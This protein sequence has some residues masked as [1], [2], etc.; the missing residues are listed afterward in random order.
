LKP[1]ICF[2]VLFS[3]LFVFPYVIANIPHQQSHATSSPAENI[4]YEEWLCRIPLRKPEKPPWV[5]FSMQGRVG[6]VG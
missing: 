3:F 5:P 1:L 2:E 4:D 6:V